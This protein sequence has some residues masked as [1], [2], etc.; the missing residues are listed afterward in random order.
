MRKR[1]RAV[2]VVLGLVASLAAV[3]T[4][5]GEPAESKIDPQAS[6]LI[7]RWSEG[8]GRV[9]NLRLRIEDTI[10]QVLQTGQKV[11][12]SH[13]RTATV[14]A[15]NKLRMEVVGDLANISM[16]KD[17]KTFTI[18]DR[19]RNEYW[20][21]SAPGTID[22]T[23]DMLLDRYGITTP[24]ADFLTADPGKVLLSQVEAGAY[25]GLHHVGEK[26][27]HHLLFSQEN[28]DWQLWMQEADRPRIAKLVITYKNEAGQ[29]QYTA[30]VLEAENLEKVPAETFRF[31]PPAGAKK[32]EIP[33]KGQIRP[34]KGGNAR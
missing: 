31:E 25:L 8:V 22:E 29:P 19:D 2:L 3:R 15:P 17:D 34:A 5:S 7:W 33:P 30:R 32:I 1:A 28:I 23:M 24:L 14:S 11:Q 26:K 10:D 16:W 27:C 18:L 13:V 21:V 20:Q 6:D 12:Y 9:T 4:T